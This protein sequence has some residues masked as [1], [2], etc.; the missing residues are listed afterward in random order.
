MKTKN[1]LLK[2]SIL[3]FCIANLLLVVLISIIFSLDYVPFQLAPGI[4]ALILVWISGGKKGLS[5][6]FQKLKYDKDFNKWYW[7]ALLAPLAVCFISYVASSLIESDR[8]LFPN[9]HEPFYVFLIECLVIIIGSYGEEIGWRGFL[10][11]KLQE[12][13]SLLTSSLIIGLV[14]GI[15]HLQLRFGLP[16]FFVYLFLVMELSLVFSWITNKTGNNILAAVILHSTFNISTL[17]FYGHIF[18]ANTPRNDTMLLLYV[19]IVLILLV[20]CGFIV[21]NMLYSQKTTQ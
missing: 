12:R 20:P 13:H 11:P 21:K 19:T 6:L 15:W 18:S 4:F 5:G 7:F 2:Y 3:I 10:L 14:W 8:L 17:F 16:V 9:L 1:T